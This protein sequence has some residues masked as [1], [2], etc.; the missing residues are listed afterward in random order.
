[1]AIS[2]I[3]AMDKNRLI[4]KGNELPWHIPNDF[5]WFKEKTKGKPV[6]MGR[7]TFESIGNPLPERRNVV[8]S[9]DTSYRV[10]NS[11]KTGKRYTD[12]VYTD[13]DLEHALRNWSYK[14]ELM[15]IGGAELYRAAMPFADKMYITRIDAEFKGDVFFPEYEDDWKIIWQQR[16][17]DKN[18]SF[19]FQI[20]VPNEGASH[21]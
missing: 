14:T 2:L 20:L 9:R 5:K 3:A 12:F 18:Y 10:D 7:K 15:V 6:L 11:S 13:H 8:L 4:G 1:M 21:E 19:E 16:D 17:C